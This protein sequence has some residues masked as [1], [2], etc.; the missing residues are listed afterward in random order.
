MKSL[1][2]KR[3]KGSEVTEKGKITKERLKNHKMRGKCKERIG[4]RW[5]RRKK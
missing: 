4:G 5:L 1:K 2:W 3:K